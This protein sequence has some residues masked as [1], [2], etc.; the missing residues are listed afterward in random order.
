MATNSNDQAPAAPDFGLAQ[1][2]ALAASSPFISH[3]QM[4][5]TAVDGKAGL[6]EMRMPLLPHL[7]RDASVRQFHGGP[8]A[9]LIDT[10]GAWSLELVAIFPQRFLYFQK[11]ARWCVTRTTVARAVASSDSTIRAANIEAASILFEAARR[12]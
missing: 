1:L 11:T 2:Q 3:C 6:V 4:T 7:M 10:A 8:I 5:V 12:K 9:S